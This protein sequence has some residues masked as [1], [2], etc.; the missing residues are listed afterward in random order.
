MPGLAKVSFARRCYCSCAFTCA[1]MI[2]VYMLTTIDC[3]QSLFCSRICG[4]ERTKDT[5]EASRASEPQVAWA[6]EGARNSWLCRLCARLTPGILCSFCVL[7]REY[8][9]Q[10]RDCLQSSTTTTQAE[11]HAHRKRRDFLFFRLYPCIYARIV[12]VLCLV[13]RLVLM[14]LFIHARAYLLAS[15]V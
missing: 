10:K 7:S 1:C 3:K 13:L 9:E 2:L 12:P 11:E 15:N 5:R 4:E 14:L 6:Q 8:L